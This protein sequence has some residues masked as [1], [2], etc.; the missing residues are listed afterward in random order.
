MLFVGS[1]NRSFIAAAVLGLAC[2]A[3]SACTPAGG[4]SSNSAPADVPRTI[5]TAQMAESLAALASRATADPQQNI[6]LNKQRADVIQARL[7][8]ESGGEAFYDRLLLA[9]E[10]LRAGD[11]RQ[12]VDDMN[13]LI[14]LSHLTNDSISLR[15]K[16]VF[17]LAALA[18]LRLGEQENCI[19][20]LASNVCILPLAGAA[21]HVRQEGARGAIS[22]LT[23]ILRHF[24]DDYASQW[25]LN[26]AYMQVGGYPD[27]VPPQYRIPDLRPKPNDPFPTFENI[28][29]FLGVNLLGRAGALSVDDFNGDGLLDIFTTAWGFSDPIHLFLADGHGGFIDR[30]ASAGLNGI[31]GGNNTADADFDNDGKVDIF[32]TRGGWLGEAG[33]F[34]KSLLRNRGDGSFEDVTFSAG[35]ASFHPSQTAAWADFNLDGYVDLFVGNESFARINGSPSHRSQLFLNNRNGTFTE[36]SHAVGIDVDDFVKGVAWGDVNHDGL[37]DLYVSVL[38][39]KNKLFINK[40]GVLPNDWHFEE[41]AAAAGVERPLSSFPTWFFD[42]DQDGWDDLLVLSYDVNEH[43]TD[44]VAREFLGLP[45]RLTSGGKTVSVETTRLYRNNHDGTFTDVSERVGL[46]S[47]AIY[48]MGSNFGDLDNDGFPDIY[49]GTGNP[50]MRSIIP[51][52][53]FRNVN[54]KRFEEVTLPGGFGHLQKGHAVAFADFD[55]DGDE[56]IYAVI[57]GAYEGD[58]YASV[59]FE[60]PGWAGRSWLTLE[61]EGRTANRSAIGARIEVAV[62]DSSGAPRTVYRTAS[63]GGS[64]GAGS[65]QQHIGLGNIAKLVSVTIH[66]PD[67]ARSVTV[68]STLTPN[69]AYHIVQ[70]EKARR[71]VRPPLPF[72]K[73]PAAA[74]SMRGHS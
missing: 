72:D 42:Y 28:A 12:A 33:R 5:G 22:R 7:V 57:G 48:A 8:Y 46:A 68:D 29:P 23:D 26:V 30:S 59:L 51:N 44:M 54:G 38:Y 1:R 61:L 21:R 10:R 64:F 6:F 56:D 32:V 31:T 70:G 35:L 67:A 9:E 52:R 47:K 15:T 71:L 74:M 36:V 39:G 45:L 62:I 19:D 34:P 24:P 14:Q 50:D 27:S 40:G 41:R 49:I 58:R 53:M 2:L 66:W 13:R 37:P 69:A 60:N 4:E 3:S 65:L 63:T 11:S 55:R 25:L 73:K 17:D 20:N 18:Y 43:M 16:P